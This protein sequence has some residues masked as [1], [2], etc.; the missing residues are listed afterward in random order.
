MRS[1]I[2]RTSLGIFVLALLLSALIVAADSVST[3]HAKNVT[4]HALAVEETPEGLRGD[5]INITVYLLW[6][7]DGEV[8]VSS[9]PLP[10]P[11][12][13]GTT[14]IT[15]SK[16]AFL[17]ASQLAGVSHHNYTVLIK[18]SQKILEIGGPSA[19]AYISIAIY[20]LLT[21]SSIRHDVTMTGL[22]LPDGLV[23]PVGGIRYKIDAARR[24]VFKVVLIPYVARFEARGAQ[25]VEVVPVIDVREAAYYLLGVNMSLPEL[26]FTKLKLSSELA[27]RITRALWSRIS[28]DAEKLDLSQEEREMM[29]SARE[30]AERENYYAAASIAYQVLISYYAR[31]IESECGYSTLCIKQYLDRVEREL[32]DVKSALRDARVTLN[33]I[34]VLVGIYNRISDAEQALERARDYLSALDVGEATRYAALAYVRTA[35]LRHWLHALTNVTGGAEIEMES[36]REAS[37]VYLEYAIAMSSYARRSGLAEHESE[38]ERIKEL[39]DRGMYVQALSYSIKITASVGSSMIVNYLRGSAA[40]VDSKDV[41]DTLYNVVKHVRRIAVNYVNALLS[42]SMTSLLP[43]M[44][45]EYGDYHLRLA[46]SAMSRGDHRGAFEELSQALYEYELAA[47]YASMIAQMSSAR[48]QISQS[49]APHDN[50][51]KPVQQQSITVRFD[52]TY[53]AVAIALAAMALAALALTYFIAIRREISRTA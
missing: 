15:S 4:I 48:A 26:N 51:V 25:G 37:A 1:T 7:G 39:Y 31:R 5:I 17:V 42:K 23:G 47:H 28:S 10:S 35:T 9:T 43:I 36:L 22:I 50:V 24:H 8:Y 18:P 19:S 3:L 21:N 53:L 38:V 12:Q 11:T 27:M 13:D 14:F 33:S 41:L 40:Y 52:E 44:Y 20:A 34:D 49:S 32:S 29:R 16:M 45:V 2:V 30:E 6:P 46:E